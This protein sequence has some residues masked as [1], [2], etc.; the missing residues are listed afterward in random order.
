MQ[1]SSLYGARIDEEL[2][3][4]DSTRLFTTA[5]RKF[6]VNEGIR[7]FADLT[8]CYVRESTVSCSHGVSEYSVL[9]TVNIPGADFSRLSK[10]QPEY[11]L[12]SSGSSGT[13]IYRSGDD[14]RRTTVEELNERYPGWRNSTAGTPQVYYE[15]MAGGARVIGL[16]PPPTK[17]SSQTATLR[18]PY[19][20]VPFTLTDDTHVPFQQSSGG[21]ARTD[22]APYHMAFAHYAAH[23]LEKLRVAPDDSARQLQLF[24]SYVQRYTGAKTPKGGVSVKPAFSYFRASR[25]GPSGG[26]RSWPTDTW[27]DR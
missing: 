26:V 18:L 23:Q 25:R 2:G 12:V 10:Q 7:Q 20:A 4:S 16:W 19:V 8:E 5:R 1:F 9:S 27:G 22:L 24:A 14:L 17:T 21:A 15:R 11:T 3:N 13:T 6:G